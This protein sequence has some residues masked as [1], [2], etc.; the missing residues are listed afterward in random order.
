ME[1]AAVWKGLPPAAASFLSPHF[2][3]RG[4]GLLQEG[5][6]LGGEAL[7]PC[8]QLLARAQGWERK[9]GMLAALL[10]KAGPYL[11]GGRK[12]PL[13][14]PTSAE[15]DGFARWQDPDGPAAPQGLLRVL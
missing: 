5:G 9:P 10:G 12:A 11:K 4:T 14:A 2:G 7:L 8:H 13:S 3:F 6:R 1:Q 15:P